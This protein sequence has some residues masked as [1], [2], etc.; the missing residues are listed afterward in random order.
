VTP[1]KHSSAA[2]AQGETIS[3]AVAVVQASYSRLTGLIAPI[4]VLLQQHAMLPSA[5]THRTVTVHSLRGFLLPRT[6]KVC[7]QNRRSSSIDAG[8][9]AAHTRRNAATPSTQLRTSTTAAAAAPALCPETATSPADQDAVVAVPL[10]SNAQLLKLQQLVDVLLTT[11]PEP[12]GCC[13]CHNC[14]SCT[15]S[16]CQQLVRWTSLG[17]HT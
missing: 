14:Y 17:V 9:I 12:G 8:C 2:V 16:Q 1:R 4:A 11:E 13:C 15:A 6:P 5:P 10:C 7:L 3:Y